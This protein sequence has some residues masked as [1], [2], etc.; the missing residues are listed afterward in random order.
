MSMSIFILFV[1]GFIILI[2]VTLVSR[3]SACLGRRRHQGES[4]AKGLDKT[5]VESLPTFKYDERR[6]NDPPGNDTDVFSECI[7]C[8]MEFQDGDICRCLP[9]CRHRFHAD[10]VDMWFLSHTICPTCRTPVEITVMRIGAVLLPDRK[11]NGAESSD[12]TAR[13]D[14][15]GQKSRS[16]SNVALEEGMSEHT[17]RIRMIKASTHQQGVCATDTDVQRDLPLAS[18]ISQKS[19]QIHPP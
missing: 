18:H 8:L 16:L 7:V 4:T 1:I 6:L 5:F 2:V 3:A 12:S 15:M 19:T 10:C 14:N 17:H 9:Q 11:I 13:E